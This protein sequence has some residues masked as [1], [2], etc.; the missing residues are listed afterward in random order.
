VRQEAGGSLV[1]T[2]LLH[3]VDTE[4]AGLFIKIN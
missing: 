1:L 3:V 4:G 2:G